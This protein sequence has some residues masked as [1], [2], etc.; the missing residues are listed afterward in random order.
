MSSPPSPLGL[1]LG[2]S[3]PGPSLVLERKTVII[4]VLRICIKPTFV[5]IA[6]TKPSSRILTGCVFSRNLLGQLVSS[7]RRSR[8]F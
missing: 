5:L 6:V 3:S 4:Q 2:A 7:Q 8:S 1:L